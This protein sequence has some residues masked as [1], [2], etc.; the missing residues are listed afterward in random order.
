M[1]S[2]AYITDGGSE[3]RDRFYVQPDTVLLPDVEL[4]VINWKR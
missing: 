1:C 4:G 2:V 3:L